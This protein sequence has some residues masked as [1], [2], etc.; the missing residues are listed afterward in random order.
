MVAPTRVDTFKYPKGEVACKY[1][2]CEDDCEVDEL[3]RAIDL[4][5]LKCIHKQF[6]VLAIKLP[7]NSNEILKTNLKRRWILKKFLKTVFLE[8]SFENKL[9]KQGPTGCANLFTGVFGKLRA[10]FDYY[11][12]D[13]TRNLR[14]CCAKVLIGKKKVWKKGPRNALR[15]LREQDGF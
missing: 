2:A 4:P 14:T 5:L 7:G 12:Q 1:C 6:G 15:L 13:Q 8:K 9:H 11:K 3:A 10:S